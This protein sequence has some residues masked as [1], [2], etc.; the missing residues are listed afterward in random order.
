MDQ[1]DGAS[2]P[3]TEGGF[4]GTFS[5]DGRWVVYSTTQS[6]IKKV[7]VG[8]GASITVCDGNTSQGA[9]WGPDDTIL[10]SGGRG[11][12]RVPAGG[13]APE[14]VTTVDVKA[15]ET[16][17]SHPQFLPN[18]RVLFTIATAGDTYKI[19]SLDLARKS[20]QVI[21]PSAGVRAR[22]VP[23]GHLVYLRAGTLFALPFHLENMAPAGKE[24]PVIEGV[25][26]TGP[27]NYADYTVSDDGL[28]VYV[29]GSAGATAG[30]TYGWADRKGG[31]Q[32]I[33]TN[34]QPW[35]TGRLSPD[36]RRIA[37]GLS[38]PGG[39]ERD[40]WV[41]DIARNVSTRLTFEGTADNPIWTPD[42][43]R[44]IYGGQIAGKSG[45]YSVPSDAS[46]GPELLLA[47]E[48]RVLPT[49]TTPD[50]KTIVYTLQSQATRPKIMIFAGEGQ[51][52][53]LHGDVPFNE[54]RGQISPDGKW[55][56][57]ESAESGSQEIYVTPFPGPGAKVRISQNGG[58]W[59]RWSRNMRELFF[60]AGAPPVTG[61][62][63]VPIQPGAA[64]QAGQPELLFS[65]TSG[66]TWDPSPDGK[67]FLVER[68]SALSLGIG[69]GST[70]AAV[71]GWFDEL[72]RRAPATK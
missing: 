21:V 62:M 36:G 5:P 6:K 26:T 27:P 22:Y 48:G 10:Y 19:A 8:G 59:P 67:Q 57:Y 7:Q 25:S 68:S 2:L 58:S 44:L 1:F 24:A 32:A 35:G 16:A 33:T 69:G 28:L 64:F 61:L 23:S 29:V 46:S 56:A 34:P 4:F 45:I 3:G 47:V 12:W 37:N 18:G 43:R 39:V 14:A 13:G 20:Y 41:F 71:S 49:S 11:L 72:K 66:T 52:R 65:Y 55:L 17:H 63:T 51:P 53:A 70:L 31:I 15:G 50:G 60:W 42:G 40:I 9:A 54:A 38:R 30:S